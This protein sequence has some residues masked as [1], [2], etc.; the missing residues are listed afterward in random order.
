MRSPSKTIPTPI[1]SMTGVKDTDD[2]LHNLPDD[3]PYRL[4]NPWVNHSHLLPETPPR[5]RRA[6]GASPPANTQMP[7]S[8]TQGAFSRH[9]RGA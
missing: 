9:L 2:I 1:A 4:P 3:I 6:S 5:N 7:Q 8:P